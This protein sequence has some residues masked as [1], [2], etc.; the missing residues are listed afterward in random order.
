[1]VKNL[2]QKI[3]QW[4]TKD[5]VKNIIVYF[6]NALIISGLFLLF[7]FLNNKAGVSDKKVSDCFSDI[8]SFIHVV[9][10][11]LI[12][13]SLMF[14]FYYFFDR[15]FLKKTSN[16]Q[17]M[18]FIMELSMI[19]TYLFGIYIDLTLR[20]IALI[21]LLTAFMSN[22]KNA[23][24]N[25]VVFC[26]LIYIIDVYSEVINN[27]KEYI[28]FIMAIASSIVAVLVVDK[29]YS[30][31]MLLVK[32]LFISLYTVL[33]VAILLI[34][35]N[36][37][38]D[39]MYFVRIFAC[40]FCSGPLA[41]ALFIVILPFFEAV[42][43][44]ITRFRLSELTDH[45]SW[46]I[47]RLIDE[48]PGTFNHSITV[49]N[50]AEACAT[51]IDEDALL[52]RTCA[53]YHDIGKLR[54][55]EFFSENLTKQESPHN[56]LTPE[57]STNIIKAHAT[58]GYNLLIKNHFPSEIASVC[59]EHHGTM[60]IYYFY[61]KAQKYTD[62]EVNITNYCYSG[63]KPQSKISAII[64]IADAS[65]AA[66]RTLT[67]R[68]REKVTKTVEKIIN[69]RMDMGQFDECDLTLK[70]ISIIKNTIINNI[71]GIYHNR[72]EYPRVVIN[73]EQMEEVK[74]VNE[75]TNEAP[76]KE[77]NNE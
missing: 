77:D 42:F 35:K 30:R 17:M 22:K 51:A 31:L 27:S 43:N 71:A 39:A 29:A 16:S 70:E 37:S 58:D 8:V 74:E 20:P 11:V 55:P 72:V 75:N 14:L 38:N 52:A 44:K 26:I 47:K 3:E 62:G 33:G 66:T 40:A 65:E 45:K 2:S 5:Y 36:S 53:Y 23:M 25:S 13:F 73:Q 60:P 18:F 56:E 12:L 67:D 49:S 1:M 21:A 68:S 32:S 59:R 54:H 7:I 28:L 57:L 19:I 9:A 24:F 69:D 48:A 41:V 50:I 4:K 34:V 46:L 15:N 10:I 61:A 6:I 64:M 63:P 76:V